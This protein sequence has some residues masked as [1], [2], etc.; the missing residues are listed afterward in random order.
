M[1]R[2]ATIDRFPLQYSTKENL[3][4]L[5]VILLCIYSLVYTA[6][7][8]S[9]SHRISPAQPQTQ[10]PLDLNFYMPDSP[11]PL[12]YCASDGQAIENIVG[13]PSRTVDSPAYTRPDSQFASYLSHH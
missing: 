9:T 3:F 12:N 5:S 4:P 10:P 7:C 6:S 2:L 11:I 1:I 8:I 13:G